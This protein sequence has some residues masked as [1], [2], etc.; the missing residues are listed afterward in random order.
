MPELFHYGEYFI[1][2]TKI[3]CVYC[4]DVLSEG[5][6]EYFVNTVIIAMQITHGALVGQ[7]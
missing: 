5:L 4:A 3:G 7:R 2:V 1:Q 6:I